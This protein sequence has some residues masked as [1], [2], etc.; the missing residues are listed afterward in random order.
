MLCGAAF[1]GAQEAWILVRTS[2][3]PA[4]EKIFQ[5]QT[6]ADKLTP[7]LRGRRVK[8]HRLQD[9]ISVLKLTAEMDKIRERLYVNEL[10]NV[11]EEARED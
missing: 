11:C 5:K 4:P 7:R 3:S 2:Q 10:K 8:L 1:S 9:D 6:S